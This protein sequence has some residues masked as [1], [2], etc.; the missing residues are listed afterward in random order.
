MARIISCRQLDPGECR[1]N[2]PRRP[3]ATEL[4]YGLC[5]VIGLRQPDELYSSLQQN[6]PVDQKTQWHLSQVRVADAVHDELLAI[7]SHVICRRKK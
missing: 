3:R 5:R 2:H 6:V 4:I 1:D 7:G